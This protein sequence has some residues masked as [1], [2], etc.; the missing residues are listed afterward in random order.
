MMKMPVLFIGHGS[1]INIVSDN[2][3][4]QSLT[5]LG[6]T[7][8]EPQAVLVI[9]AHW[10]TRS[11]YISCSKKPTTIYDFYGFP[12]ELYQV[13]YNCP[14]AP[15]KASLVQALTNGKILGDYERG[16]DHA[17]WSVL[18]HMYPDANIPVMEMSLDVMKSPQDHYEMGK[19]FTALRNE[20]ILILG[21]GNMVHNLSK[22]NFAQLYGDEYPWAVQC[23]SNM[24]ELIVKGDHASLI[25]YQQLPNAKLAIPTNE[26]YLPML[27]AL[28]LQ[29]ENDTL[30]FTCT[31]MQ[32]GSISM[33]SFII[34][35]RK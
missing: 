11:T 15:E 20:G 5:M 32:N 31:D 16:L 28:A 3:Y 7:L 30:E 4:T 14:G 19:K 24:A 2:S 18:K 9:S 21:S 33:R 13:T 10:Q 26:H 34:D 8:P 6:R 27:Y 23:D 35:E 12:E 29:E 1:P 25:D 22:V 17:A